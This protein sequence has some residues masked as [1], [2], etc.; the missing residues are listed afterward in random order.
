MSERSEPKMKSRRDDLIV[1]QGKRGTSVAL[2]NAAPHSSPSPREE[3]AGRGL[4]RGEPS[5]QMPRPPHQQETRPGPKTKPLQ[6]TS[7]LAPLFLPAQRPGAPELRC[8]A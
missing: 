6:A 1:A 5:C 3:R 2:G 8:S 7:G 4:G